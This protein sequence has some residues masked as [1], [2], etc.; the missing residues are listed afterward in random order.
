MKFI[1][2]TGW[3]EGT[4]ALG[5][6][7]A[8][9]L[10]HKRVLWLVCG[11]S[12]IAAAVKVMDSLDEAVTVRLAIFLTD[13]RFGELGHTHSN[14]KQLLDSGFHTKQ[15]VFVPV[16]NAGFTQEE[17]QER[18]A[19]ALQT[20]FAH[21]DIVIAQFGI[22]ADGHIAGILPNSPATTAEEWVLAYDA[23][24]YTRVTLTF[25]ALRQVDVAYALVMGEDKRTA[26]HKL[27][28]EN[29]P[30]GEQPSQILKELPE[31]YVFS[32]QVGSK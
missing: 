13:E 30:L 25:P 20:A 19:Q 28:T 16:L 6:R 26:L 12:N 22:G 32:D 24:P 18:Y 2:T 31:A 9:E 5:K 10:K 21:A 8:S 23:P 29:L 27:E 17:T 11:G 4:Q 3:D 15:A 14:A 7:L 1:R